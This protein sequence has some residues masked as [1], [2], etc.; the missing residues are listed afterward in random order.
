M[1]YDNL[2][3]PAYDTKRQIDYCQ[4][5]RLKDCV[6]CLHKIKKGKLPNEDPCFGCHSKRHCKSGSCAARTRYELLVKQNEAILDEGP[7]SEDCIK[8]HLHKGQFIT[9]LAPR[10]PRKSRILWINNTSFHTED[11]TYYFEEH[12]KLWWFSESAARR[13]VRDKK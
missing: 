2:K 4:G 10:G 1:G 5:C 13:S 3:S 9:I 6:N 12:R 8:R 11:D 7:L